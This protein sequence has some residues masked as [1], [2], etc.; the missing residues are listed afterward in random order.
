[1][2]LLSPPKSTTDQILLGGGIT[3]GFALV[4]AGLA[5]MN[6][7]VSPSILG[8]NFDTVVGAA[9]GTALAA[10]VGLAAA[11]FAPKWRTVGLGM[12]GTF[13]TAWAASSVVR[14]VSP[15]APQGSLTGG[16]NYNVTL[17]Q[18]TTLIQRVKV[19]DTVT[20]LAPSGW[21]VPSAS[22]TFL[23]EVAASSASTSS[24]TFEA[25]V[26]GSGNV[27]SSSPDG[28]STATVTIDA[29]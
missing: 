25:S 27:T 5:R 15:Q 21:T 7:E 18:G 24:T 29:S 12:V 3:G 6:S 8:K 23:K 13:G 14:A 10:I 19:G 17:I 26:S 2:K 28:S 4:G 16:Q 9:E 20:V 11:I 1:M 22:S